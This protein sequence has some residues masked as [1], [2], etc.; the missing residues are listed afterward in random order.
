[1]GRSR[2]SLVKEF[3]IKDGKFDRQYKTTKNSKVQITK[4]NTLIKV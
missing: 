4:S 2:N 1:M 3:S